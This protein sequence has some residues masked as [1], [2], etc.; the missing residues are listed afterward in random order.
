[1]FILLFFYI[2][3]AISCFKEIIEAE[4]YWTKVAKNSNGKK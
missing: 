4:Q 3:G 2:G 1:V